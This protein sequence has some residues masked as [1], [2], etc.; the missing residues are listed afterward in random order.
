M[1]PENYPNGGLFESSAIFFQR[2]LFRKIPSGILL[3]V[4]NILDPD[5]DD[6]LLGLIWV[7]TDCNRYQQMTKYITSRYNVFND[8]I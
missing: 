1:L 6:I 7:Q 3:T 8:K 5:P 2:E 4:S